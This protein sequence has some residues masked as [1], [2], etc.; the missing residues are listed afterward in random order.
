MEYRPS[1]EFR[2]PFSAAH[3]INFSYIHFLAKIFPP[4]LTEIL[5][6][7]SLVQ[8]YVML[9]CCHHHHVDTVSLAVQRQLCAHTIYYTTTLITSQQALSNVSV[10]Q[11]H[12]EMLTFWHQRTNIPTGQ[13]NVARW[14]FC[15]FWG[16]AHLSMSC[17]NLTVPCLL[18]W[19]CVTWFLTDSDIPATSYDIYGST[20]CIQYFEW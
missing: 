8:Y 11:F 4:K 10:V 5:C 15:T 1:F 12:I 7:C 19:F 20:R 9:S 14:S 3:F 17:Q 2:N 6:L 13:E 18:G 16:A